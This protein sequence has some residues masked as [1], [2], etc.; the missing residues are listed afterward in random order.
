M[1]SL[2]KVELIH[3]GFY[4]I[5]CKYIICCCSTTDFASISWLPVYLSSSNCICQF[6]VYTEWLTLRRFFCNTFCKRNVIKLSSHLKLNCSK[7][8]KICWCVALQMKS[9]INWN[10]VIDFVKLLKTFFKEIKL[11]NSHLDTA[12]SKYLNITIV[13]NLIYNFVLSL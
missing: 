7:S 8:F 13:L 9:F 5:H 3:T 11:C 12:N 6:H 2:K 10:R 4:C 1:E